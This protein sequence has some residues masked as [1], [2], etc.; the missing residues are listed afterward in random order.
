MADSPG[1]D[2]LLLPVETVLDDIPELALNDTEAARLRNGQKLLF[3]SRADV[4][5]LL[6]IGIDLEI[7]TEALATCHGDPV[8]LIMVKG[9]EISS[10]RVLNL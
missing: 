5:R 2:E 4:D 9:A 10:I 1:L 8:A 6:R 7:E 3:V